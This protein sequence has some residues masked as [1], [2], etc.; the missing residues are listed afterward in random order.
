MLK[1]KSREDGLTL[2]TER[3]VYAMILWGV[4]QGRGGDESK[5]HG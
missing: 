2:Q 5:Q 1:T 3:I 4:W